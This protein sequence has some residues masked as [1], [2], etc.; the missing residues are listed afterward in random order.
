MGSIER[1]FKRKN[2]NK[3]KKDAEKEMAVKVALFSKLPDTCLTCEQSFDKTNK[4]MVTTW[5]VVVREKEDV[6]RLYCPT[7]WK[8]AVKIIEDFKEHLKEKNG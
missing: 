1:K 6:V 7:C 4:E 3:A 5:N 8:S 2:G